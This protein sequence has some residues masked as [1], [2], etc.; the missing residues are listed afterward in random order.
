MNDEVKPQSSETASAVPAADAPVKQRRWIRPL[1]IL[2]IIAAAVTIGAGALC[3]RLAQG[4]FHA[5]FLTGFLE[6][7]LSDDRGLTFDIG[8][9]SM[10]WRGGRT[11]VGFIMRDIHVSGVRGDFMT[12]SDADI[13]ISPLYLLMGQLH[14]A[15]ADVSNLDLR[16]IRLPDGRITLTGTDAA[17]KDKPDTTTVGLTLSDIAQKMPAI[18]TLTLKDTMIVFEDQKD[19]IIRRFEDVQVE[20]TQSGGFL[21]RSLSGSITAPLTGMEDDNTSNAAIDFIYNADD[22]ILTVA[23]SIDHANTR[24]LIGPWL[25]QAGLPRVDMFVEG[26]AQLQLNN[27]FSLHALNFNLKGQNGTLHWPRSY[28]EGLEDQKLTDFDVTIGFNPKTQSLEL[29]NAS[30][31]SKGLTIET[32]G[33][34]HISDNWQKMDG[35]LNLHI[36]VMAVDLLPAIWPK[37]WDSGARHW[38]VDRMDKGRFSQIDVQVPL[39][40]ELVDVPPG[41]AVEEGED[42]EAA[43]KRWSFTNGTV[44]AAFGFTGVTVD[45]RNPM[46]PAV[47]TTGTGTFEGLALTLN[48]TRATIGG[49]NVR[50]ATLFF[51]DLITPGKGDA[52]LHFDMTGPVSAVFQYMDREPI[53]YRKKVDL[54]LNNAGGQAE[55]TVDVEFPTLHDMEMED[56]H[57]KANAKLQN[58]NVDGAVKGMKLAGG[59]FDLEASENHFKI[60]GSGTLDGQPATVMWHELFAPKA[61]D[62]F[63][64]KLE[65]D[66]KT[67]KTMRQ[68]FIGTMEDRV[69]NAILPAKVSMTTLPSG[70]AALKVSADLTA[71]RIDFTNPFN[72]VK[73]AGKSARAELTGTLLK[74]EI[75]SID[76]LSITGDGLSLKSGEIGFGRDK[77]NVPIL[78]RATLKGLVIGQTDADFKA[79]WPSEYDIRADVSG[80][81]FDARWILGDTPEDAGKPNLS[82]DVALKLDR[83]YVSD[84]PLEKASGAFV[85]NTKGLQQMANLD[86]SV[87][88]SKVTLRYNA[89][90]Q[91][92][93]QLLLE[94][95]NAGAGLQALGITERV[96]GGKLTAK[97]APIQGGQPGDMQGKLVIENFSVHKAPMLAKLI[98]ILSIPGLLN[99]LNQDTG[100]NFQRAEADMTW[101]NRNGGALLQFKDGRTSGASLGLTFEGEINTASSQMAIQGTVIPMSEVNSLL[102]QIPLVGDILTGGKKNAGIFAATYKM[103]GSTSDPAVSVNPLSVLTPGILRR[104]LFESGTPKTTATKTPLTPTPA[105]AQ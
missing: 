3:W 91:P 53:A 55:L 72:A 40:A 81:S 75:Q 90:G 19:A 64:S 59:P 14:I 80:P 30:I 95:E 87:Q 6:K 29:K 1:C 104:I 97:A 57:V 85:G 78:S 47:N 32:N 71:A 11:P 27:D 102:A 79:E 2:G 48:V 25:R 49:L 31:T 63:A 8:D 74:N 36:P 68:K 92:T 89:S 66:L 12:I 34:L 21:K 26:R 105:P 45:Y 62:A 42:P 98:N 28:G 56:V 94:L 67:S 43:S 93:D 7:S 16:V 33:S 24:R 4:P 38:L 103:Q 61:N 17:E 15:H 54:N 50:K 37:V 83:L 84:V 13:G 96:R 22:D 86:A 51:D 41:E 44:K 5:A 77:D 23:A 88:N 10:V 101:L 20:M 18:D 9:L 39:T 70:K 76:S 35:Q 46:L 73:D 65:A 100:L 52:K 99:I 60:S 69:D 82:Y 58:L